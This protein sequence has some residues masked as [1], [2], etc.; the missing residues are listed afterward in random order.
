MNGFMNI[1]K[2]K[3][4]TSHDVVDSVRRILNLQKVGHLGTLDPAATGVLPICVGKATKLA[5]YLVSREKRYR[6]T[7]RLGEETDTGDSSGTVT[8]SFGKVDIEEDPIRTAMRAFLGAYDQIPPMFSAIKVG[9][10]P[11][12]KKARAGKVVER[13][14]RRVSIYELVFLEKTGRDVTFEVLCSKGTYIRSLCEDLGRKLGVGAHLSELRRLQVGSFS[15]GRAISVEK[16]HQR[17][18]EGRLNEVL[19][20]MDEVLPL[21]LLRVNF[22]AAQRVLCGNPIFRSG[23]ISIPEE[24]SEGTRL[25]VHNSEDELLA[26]VSALKEPKGQVLGTEGPL[27]KVETVLGSPWVKAMKPIG[28]S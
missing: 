22:S 10:I 11:L 26:I 13:K 16:L 21:P 7:M 5:A 6:A 18:T 17:K 1:D 2:A 19:Y 14:P 12:Y 28:V 8:R 25:K 4:V 24:F 20:S 15:I 27:F 23:I 9:G 3:G